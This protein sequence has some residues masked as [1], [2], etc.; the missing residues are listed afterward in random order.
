MKK[1]IP[2]LTAIVLLFSATAFA[3]AGDKVTAKVK[4]AFEKDFQQAQNVSWEKTGGFYF[5][6]FIMND[7][8]V[9][10]LTTKQEN[11]LIRQEKL[12]QASYL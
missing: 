1:L 3:A 10:A 12:L 11:W 8:S 7:L 9:N 6:S 4:V 5:A 2:I